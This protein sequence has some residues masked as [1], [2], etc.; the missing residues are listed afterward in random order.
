MK[1][2]NAKNGDV[3]QNWWLVDATGK[4]VG[5]LASEIALVVRG[6]KKPEFTPHVDTGDNVVVINAEKV[7]FTGNKWD[8]KKYYTHSRYFGSTKQ[9]TAR[10]YLTKDAT[11]ILRFAVDG[12]LPKSKLGMKLRNKVKIF[13]G[14]THD[15]KAQK[16]EALNL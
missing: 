14:P 7:K 4:T 12:M 5:R 8:E 1:T 16:P 10:E 6:K 11:Q 2:W 9:T 3:K 15:L 13:K